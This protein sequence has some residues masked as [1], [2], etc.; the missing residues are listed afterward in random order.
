MKIIKS[1]LIG[2]F[3]AITIQFAAQAQS[4]P[5]FCQIHSGNVGQYTSQYDIFNHTAQTPYRPFVQNSRVYKVTNDLIAMPLFYA[6]IPSNNAS[7]PDNSVG[8]AFELKGKYGNHVISNKEVAV[9]HIN[10]SC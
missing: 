8:A 4:N 10:P 7:I 1:G 6:R 3:A 2:L 5:Q 9:Q